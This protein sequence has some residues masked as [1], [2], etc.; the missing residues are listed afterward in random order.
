MTIHQ[1]TTL[2]PVVMAALPSTLGLDIEKA[3]ALAR[4]EKAK[5]TRKLYGTSRSTRYAATCATPSC[6]SIMRARGC[7]G[8]SVPC[9]DRLDQNQPGKAISLR[10][11]A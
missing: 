11:L 2:V 1:T 9:G 4:K 6:S 8:A 10:S 5:G 7:C 3:S